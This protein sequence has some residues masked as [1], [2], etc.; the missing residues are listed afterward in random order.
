MPSQIYIQINKFAK[1][2]CQQQL[3]LLHQ[4]STVQVSKQ[5]EEDCNFKL[6]M[7]ERTNTQYSCSPCQNGQN[8]GN[9]SCQ[10]DWS[11]LISS[12]YI[13]DENVNLS[14]SRNMSAVRF[15]FHSQTQ[16]HQ[17]L[18]FQQILNQQRQMQQQQQLPHAQQNL[19]NELM[20]NQLL[21]VTQEQA[22]KVK[23]KELLNHLEKLC[24]VSEQTK[25]NYK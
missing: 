12:K 16:Q 20:I 17:T 6:A 11:V 23:V 18:Q 3:D 14:L 5:F 10:Y 8:V 2:Y 7:I 15:L 21:N 4:Q 19:S 13:Y 1:E 24:T 9:Q 22:Q 25:F